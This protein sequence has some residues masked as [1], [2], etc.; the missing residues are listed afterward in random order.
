M[1]TGSQVIQIFT[2]TTVDIAC[3][4]HYDCTLMLMLPC[5]VVMPA[6]PNLVRT[7]SLLHFHFG[8]SGGAR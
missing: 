4:T 6:L 5:S 1:H 3:S 8:E 2:T 7:T